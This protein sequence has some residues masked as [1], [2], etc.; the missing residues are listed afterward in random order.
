VLRAFADELP[1]GKLT[2]TAYA[3]ARAGHPEWPTRNTVAMAFGSWER[4]LAAAGLTSRASE[5]RRARD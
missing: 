3:A 4:A 1:E 5:W 2:C